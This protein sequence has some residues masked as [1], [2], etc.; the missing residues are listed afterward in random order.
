MMKNKKYPEDELTQLKEDLL[1]NF[2]ANEE[3][4]ASL[5]LRCEAYQTNY[6]FY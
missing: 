1:V 4:K 6:R 2:L 3:R 5:L